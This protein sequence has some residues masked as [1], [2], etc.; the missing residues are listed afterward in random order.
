M[1]EYNKLEIVFGNFDQDLNAVM[2]FALSVNISSIS[3]R[4]S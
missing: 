3:Y 4:Y 1:N 2:L